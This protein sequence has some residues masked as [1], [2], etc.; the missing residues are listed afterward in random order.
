MMR[1]TSW[2]AGSFWDGARRG[3]YS[4]PPRA[5]G[6]EILGKQG[7]RTYFLPFEER[8]RKAAFSEGWIFLTSAGLREEEGDFFPFD[9]VPGASQSF[10]VT[11][12][13]AL[14]ILLPNSMPQSTETKRAPL[15]VILGQS[16]N[17]DQRVYH[18]LPFW[19]VKG[20]VLC[21]DGELIAL[22]RRIARLRHDFHEKPSGSETSALLDAVRASNHG[23]LREIL[24]DYTLYLP[25]LLDEVAEELLRL[26]DPLQPHIF[27]ERKLD[28]ILNEIRRTKTELSRQYNGGNDTEIREELE[29]LEE[30]TRKTMDA[31]LEMA[32]PDHDLSPLSLSRLLDGGFQYFDGQ[33]ITEVEILLQPDLHEAYLK[34]RFRKNGFMPDDWGVFHLNDE[35]R[36]L[37]LFTLDRHANARDVTVSAVADP[38]GRIVFLVPGLGLARHDG[39]QFAWTD[40]SNPMKAMDRLMG[41]DASGILYFSQRMRGAAGICRWA[42]DESRDYRKRQEASIYPVIRTGTGEPVAQDDRGRIWFI[43]PGFSRDPRTGMIEGGREVFELLARANQRP[44]ARIENGIPS[45]LRKVRPGNDPS[46]Y[47]IEEGVI[48]HCYSDA[49]LASA[50]LLPGLHGSMIAV[51]G[52]G[53]HLILEDSVYTAADLHEMAVKQFGLF[54]EA[55]PERIRFSSYQYF[56]NRPP[57]AFCL[58]L[59][60]TL[61]ILQGG[62]LE[63]YREGTPLGIQESVGAFDLSTPYSLL[64]GRL[65]GSSPKCVALV[66]DFRSPGTMIW[67]SQQGGDIY[68]WIAHAAESAR[69]EGEEDGP[70][71]SAMTVNGMPIIDHQRGLLYFHHGVDRVLE[72]SGP[73]HYRFRRDAGKPV[74]LTRAGGLILRKDFGSYKG[75]RL[76]SQGTISDLAATFLSPLVPVHE[77]KDGSLLCLTPFGAAWIRQ[78]PDGSFRPG[79]E[80]WVNMPHGMLDYVGRS[81]SAIYLLSEDGHLVAVPAE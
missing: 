65:R 42:Y 52:R 59:D 29:R 9:H 36:L 20:A 75:Y 77:E 4:S 56:R 28:W 54:I 14:A 12:E 67:F 49:L 13:Q 27:V 25:G 19:E 30:E 68:H 61:W 21:R 43:A 23:M 62:K 24:K 11:G 3:K 10:L 73:S 51:S 80:L 63:A 1:S 69:I 41:C 55:A 74:L 33:W 76:L 18:N 81:E 5:R 64:I 71:G 70:P 38:G 22:G 31:C 79:G 7:S 45:P 26:P 47:C 37:P 15:T 34:L 50:C 53:A 60:D 17:W 32:G 72:V 44:M 35:G 58:G 6:G 57:P 2:S 46:L 8:F 16:G 66:P 39:K 78:G 48:H 40:R